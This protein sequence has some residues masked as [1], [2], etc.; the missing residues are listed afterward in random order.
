M[1]DEDGDSFEALQP[2]KVFN[3]VLQR[4]YQNMEIRAL[5]PTAEIQDLDPRISA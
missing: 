5:D 2:K 4:V 1:K 3:P